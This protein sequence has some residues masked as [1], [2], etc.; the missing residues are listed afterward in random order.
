MKE[1]MSNAEVVEK[2]EENCMWVAALHVF[3]LH[4]VRHCAA[5]QGYDQHLNMVLG[6]AEETITIIEKEEETG[7]EIVQVIQH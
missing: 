5:L 7:E 4:L 3:V 1:F 6:D 2:F